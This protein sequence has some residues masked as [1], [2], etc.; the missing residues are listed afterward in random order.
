MCSTF[1]VK[2]LYCSCLEGI[3]VEPV[4]HFVSVFLLLLLLL[5]CCVL[6]VLLLRI[7]DPVATNVCNILLFYLRQTITTKFTS[8]VPVKINERITLKYIS[9][10]GIGD[11]PMVQWVNH[12]VFLWLVFCADLLHSRPLANLSIPEI[13]HGSY[14]VNFVDQKI[15]NML[16]CSGSRIYGTM[17]KQNSKNT[18]SIKAFKTQT[19]KEY[20]P[21]PVSVVLQCGRLGGYR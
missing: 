17:F 14:F 19:G 1:E 5:Y 2:V 9:H 12:L 8:C 21:V 10:N 20:L 11:L 4:C 16:L 13:S 7:L 18:R 3:S 6:W 15:Q